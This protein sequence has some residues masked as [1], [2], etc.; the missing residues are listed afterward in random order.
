MN[1][2]PLC[3]RYCETVL[4]ADDTVLYC[5]SKDPK[6]LESNLNHDLQCLFE[7]FNTNLR[8]LNTSKCKFIIFGS[9]RKLKNT[10]ISIKINQSALEK[11]DSYKYLGV[12]VNQSMNWTDHID[13]IISK[14]GQRTRFGSPCQTSTTYECKIDIV[15][16][17]D[18][19]II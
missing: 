8:T 12:T 9:S 10:E 16:Q 3:P 18:Y 13:S 6:E 2:L 7:W 4:Y 14:F 1:D 5:H 17:P 19:A 11:V 15:Q